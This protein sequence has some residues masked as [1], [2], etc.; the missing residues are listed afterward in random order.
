M[1]RTRYPWESEGELCKYC[2]GSGSGLGGSC[3]HCFGLG[4]TFKG[5]AREPCSTCKGTGKKEDGTPCTKCEAKGWILAA[6]KKRKPCGYCMS[7]G[8]TLGGA[9][10]HCGGTGYMDLDEKGQPIDLAL[11]LKAAQAKCPYCLGLGY[12]MRGATCDACHGTGI[13]PSKD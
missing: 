13:A 3:K 10:K 6:A 2:L 8:K 1:Y 5:Q 4:R 9:C 11:G 7:S 12:R